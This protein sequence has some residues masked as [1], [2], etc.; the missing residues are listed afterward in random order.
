MA[1]LGFTSLPE[2]DMVNG[3]EVSVGEEFT[4]EFDLMSLEPAPLT[5]LGLGVEGG[6]WAPRVGEVYEIVLAA[7]F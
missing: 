2:P 1:Y 3:V 7:S 6:G 5:I 4:Y